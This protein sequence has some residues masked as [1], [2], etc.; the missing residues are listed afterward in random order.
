MEV[1][2]QQRQLVSDEICQGYYRQAIFQTVKAGDVVLDLGTGTGIHA[3]FSCHAGAKRVY[4][5]EQD[6]TIELAKEI[7][8]VNKLQD[9]IVFIR[10]TSSQI[11]LSEKV[12]VI[13]THLG[14]RGI[15]SY[16]IDARERFLKVGGTVIPAAMELFC[17]PLE[18][19]SVYDELVDFWS[20]DHYGINFSSM[21][22]AAVNEAAGKNFTVDR[23]LAEPLSLGQFDLQRAKETR[24][25]G[26]GCFNISRQ[27]TFH[28]L[29]VWYTL[30]L[31]D[32]ISISSSPPLALA[33]PPWSQSFFPI[34]NAVN[35][36]LGDRIAFSM[37]AFGFS[38]PRVIWT[39]RVQV[40]GREH[41]ATFT[42][43][44]FNGFP[45]DLE[46]LH[47]QAPNYKPPLNSLGEVAL[48]ILNLCDGMTPLREIEQEVFRRFSGTLRTQQDAAAFV[49]RVLKKFAT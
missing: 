42:H 1:I 48:L 10:G 19:P 22:Q 39:W 44:S 20:R 38:G 28:G 41:E 35:V 4:A 25:G 15:L 21:R 32:N 26:D 23:F 7:A 36:Q 29:G 14:F 37:K 18:W 13:V 47:K 5:I 40:E 31:T 33:S 16:L 34:N 3:L 24:V 49:A 45:L 9:R 8:R 12:D 17:A 46:A 27:G 11:E 6:D 30:W 43:S 2:E